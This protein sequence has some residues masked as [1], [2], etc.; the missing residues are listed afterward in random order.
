MEK[1]EFLCPYCKQTEA[2]GAHMAGVKIMCSHCDSFIVVPEVGATTAYRPWEAPAAQAAAP[3]EKVTG[4]RAQ[5]IE[6]KQWAEHER[7]V[8]RPEDP[9][10]SAGFLDAMAY[11]MAAVGIVAAFIGLAVSA[12]K[13][14]LTP[15]LVG[16]AVLVQCIWLAAVTSLVTGAARNI[17]KTAN[18]VRAMVEREERRT[19]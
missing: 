6:E 13:G 10:G 16:A 7:T 4:R 9:A 17:F 5:E 18:T 1:H 3:A 11:A 8:G 12:S 15:A 2:V 19:G 14:T